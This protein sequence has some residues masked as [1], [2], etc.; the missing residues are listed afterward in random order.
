MSDIKQNF[1]ATRAIVNN[2]SYIDQVENP[3][4]C[5]VIFVLKDKLGALAEV[6]KLFQ[7]YKI[8]LKLIESRSS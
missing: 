1:S 4:D 2:D 6:L 8:N 3:G 7:D 5:S